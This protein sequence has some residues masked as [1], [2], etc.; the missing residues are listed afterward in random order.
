M[1]PP[2]MAMTWNVPARCSRAVS[3]GSRPARSPIST[4]VPIAAA[5]TA[6]GPAARAIAAR[7]RAR[8]AAAHSS[9]HVPA[10]TSSTSSALLTAAVRARRRAHQVVRGIRRAVI[11]VAH[12]PP[13]RGRDGHGPAGPPLARLSG[14]ARPPPTATSTCPSTGSGHAHGPTAACV[15]ARRS[16]TDGPSTTASAVRRPVETNDRARPRR[17]VAQHAGRLERGDERRRARRR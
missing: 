14:G 16:S 11:P 7:A 15:T 8:I 9:G 17:V 13:H 6:S 5:S 12:R 2:E 4:A 1:L 3:S 10:T